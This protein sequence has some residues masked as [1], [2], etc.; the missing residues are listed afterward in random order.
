MRSLLY[1]F[2]LT[3]NLSHA[4]DTNK[5]KELK[6]LGFTNEQIVNLLTKSEK[7]TGNMD[8]NRDVF[9]IPGDFKRKME[10]LKSKKKGLV[11]VAFTKEWPVRGP[12]YLEFSINNGTAF[13]PQDDDSSAVDRFRKGH[14]SRMGIN[15]PNSTNPARSKKT[16][17]Q[18]WVKIGRADILSYLL[19]GRRGPTVHEHVERNSWLFNDYTV[20]QASDL[21]TS[22]Y[23]AEFEVPAGDLEMKVHRKFHIKDAG[24]WGTQKENRHKKFHQVAVQP[25]KITVLSYFWK[26]NARYGLDHVPSQYHLKFVDDISKRYGE[27]FREVRT[28]HNE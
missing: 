18:N 5:V 14:Q 24:I 27:Y 10:R 6:E 19:D 23:F 8:K 20:S 2:F 1:C 21:I 7:S 12:G 13:S 11:V 16:K 3:L 4:I 26:D 15:L 25:G 22:R 17:K 28:Q 9:E